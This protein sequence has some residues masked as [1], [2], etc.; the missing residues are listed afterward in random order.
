MQM[1]P[2]TALDN[3]DPNGIKRIKIPNMKEQQYHLLGA[4]I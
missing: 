4:G 2:V 3:S 1:S